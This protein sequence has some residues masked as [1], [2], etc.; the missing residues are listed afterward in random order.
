ML[1]YL[2]L[3]KD[4]MNEGSDSAEVEM[5]TSENQEDYDGLEAAMEELGGHLAAKDWKAAAECFRAAIELCESQ[6]HE[7]G[8]DS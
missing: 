4:K 2:K 5:K 1:P 6:P 8:K 7:E 3:K